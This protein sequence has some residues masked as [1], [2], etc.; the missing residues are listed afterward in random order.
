MTLKCSSLIIPLNQLWNLF[1]NHTPLDFCK[2]RNKLSLTPDG[3]LALND[4]VVIPLTSRKAALD[5]LLSGN[6]W[7]NKNKVTCRFQ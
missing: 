6:L 7:V 4:H 1:V 5:D 3:T 2:H